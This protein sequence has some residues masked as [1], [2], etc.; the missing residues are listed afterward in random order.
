M[1][2]VTPETVEHLFRAQKQELRGRLRL[3]VSSQRFPRDPAQPLDVG[4][5]VEAL[6]E[7]VIRLLKDCAEDAAHLGGTK[8]ATYFEN[9]V[10]PPAA[11]ANR[12]RV[13]ASADTF[14]PF[15]VRRL[16]E[17]LGLDQRSDEYTP[18]LHA[19]ASDFLTWARSQ[20]EARDPYGIEVDEQSGG[21]AIAFIRSERAPRES[22]A[23][24]ERGGPTAAEVGTSEEIQGGGQ[25]PSRGD[26]PLPEQKAKKPSKR[27]RGDR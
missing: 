2:L 13:L 5:A 20:P 7:R 11:M 4:C 8:T 18:A 21:Q 16:D 6:G 22:F 25:P 26:K 9:H 15:V 27:Q 17:A 1:F 23:P 24:L 12:L 19:L 10:I 14:E 3:D